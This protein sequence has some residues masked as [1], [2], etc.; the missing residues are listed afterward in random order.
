[1]QHPMAQFLEQASALHHHLC[2]RQV[3]GVRMGMYA[4]ALL[5]L[6]L[7]QAHKRL[8]TFVETDGCFA[9]GISVATGCWLGHRTLRLVDL[10]RVAATFVDTQRK[11]AIRIRPAQS[12]RQSAPRY[13]PN[14]S[15]RWHTYLA[16]YQVMPTDVLLEWE[17]VQVTLDL[18]AIVSKASARCVCATCG[19]EII[20]EREVIRD[21]QAL[22]GACAGVNRYYL[23]EVRT[24]ACA[25]AACASEGILEAWPIAL[26]RGVLADPMGT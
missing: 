15:T 9:D 18:H 7:P 20:N 6:E 26:D 17:A 2:P 5:E 4:A 10:G 22:C 16:A 24:S 12:A 19:E 25:L 13:A 3:L 14:E 23:P 21:G 8:L 11:R 1:M